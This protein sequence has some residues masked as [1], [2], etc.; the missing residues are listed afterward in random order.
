MEY[1]D[2]A[3]EIVTLI[4]DSMLMINNAG[5]VCSHGHQGTFIKEIILMI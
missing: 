1:G 2:E 3:L 5:M 4:R